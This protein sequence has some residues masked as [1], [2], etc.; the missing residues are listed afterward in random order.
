MVRLLRRQAFNPSWVS[1]FL[2]PF[3]IA[4]R[5]LWREM[6]THAASLEGRMLD[7]GCGTQ[8][9]RSLFAGREY[10]GLD[11]DSPRSRSLGIADQ[12]YDGSTFP[13]PDSAFDSVLSNQV[14]EHVFNPAQFLSEVNRVLR[15]GGRLLLTIPFVWDEHEQPFD[16]ARYS[17]FGLAHLLEEHGFRI[18]SHRKIAGDFSTLVQLTNAYVYKVLPRA[19][20]ARVIGTVLFVAPITL[21]GLGLSKLLPKN[22]DLYLDQLVLATKR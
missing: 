12:L 20:A 1:I 19:M 15:P 3:Y 17:S 4:R 11:I 7:V 2:N 14:L 18:D 10:V 22:E 21:V 5:G 9:Y 8:P 16:Y 13:F 6:A